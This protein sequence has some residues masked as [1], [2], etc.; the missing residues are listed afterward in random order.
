MH[1]DIAAEI[2]QKIRDSA[3]RLEEML[4]SDGV[5]EAESDGAPDIAG[6]VGDDGDGGDGGVAEELVED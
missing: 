6:G 2:E 4:D 5:V 3:D 1:A